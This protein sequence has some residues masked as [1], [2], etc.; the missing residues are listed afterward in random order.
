MTT[1]VCLHCERIVL[2]NKKLKH[3]EQRYC[4]LAGCQRAR[5]LLFARK[6]Y[7]KDKKFRSAKLV[8]AMAYR[9]KDR[10]KYSEYMFTYRD[11]HP[12]YV[13]KNNQKQRDRYGQKKGKKSGEEK[14]V[15]PYTLMPQQSD[16][17]HV[18]AMCVPCMSHAAHTCCKLL[19][20]IKNTNLYS[21]DYNKCVNFPE[22]ESPLRWES[23]P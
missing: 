8:K 23:C 11:S 3:H 21:S 18:Y 19:K 2:R 20:K 14:I 7:E 17:E 13:L 22:G 1:I 16:I 5:R 4:N 12:E 15:N 9:K 10:L 6:K